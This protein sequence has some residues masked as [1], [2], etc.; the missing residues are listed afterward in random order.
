MPTDRKGPSS[1]IRIVRNQMSCFGDSISTLSLEAEWTLVK[2][3]GSNRGNWTRWPLRFVLA[4]RQLDEKQWSLFIFLSSS[5]PHLPLRLLPSTYP[6]SPYSLYMNCEDSF[7]AIGNSW[8]PLIKSRQMQLRDLFF[9]SLPPTHHPKP[10]LTYKFWSH[11]GMH[12]FLPTV[13]SKTW[14]ND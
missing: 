5:C 3:R 10:L 8:S 4:L 11:H 9:F 7:A 13:A 2:D 6:T 14:S 1:A 12:L